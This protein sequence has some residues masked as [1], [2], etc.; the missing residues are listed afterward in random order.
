MLRREHDLGHLSLHPPSAHSSLPLWPSEHDLGHLS[1][2]PPSALLTL[3]RREHDLVHLSLHPPSA[4]LTLLRREHDLVH[5]SLHPLSALLTL[6]R[7]EHDLVHLPLHPPSAHSSLPLW[8]GGKTPASKE[9]D[10]GIAPR[11][12]RTRSPH[13]VRRPRRERQAWVRF[14][15]SP[16]VCFQIESYQ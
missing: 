11:F 4:L 2:H 9:A 10:K 7:R 13:W 14:S 8:P 12:P 6:L 5:L 15:L 3:L 1:L 16:G